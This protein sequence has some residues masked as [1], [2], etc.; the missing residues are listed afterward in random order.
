MRASRKDMARWVA[1]INMELERDDLR[2]ERRTTLEIK[3]DMYL[4]ALGPYCRRCARSLE[5]PESIERGLGSECV[6]AATS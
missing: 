3:R 4:R 2:A 6:K 5:D 1:T